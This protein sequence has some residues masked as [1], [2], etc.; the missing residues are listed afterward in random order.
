M[1]ANFGRIMLRQ[2]NK[3]LGVINAQ[4]LWVGSGNS[5]DTS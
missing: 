5:A 4:K 2:Y 3:V 1:Y